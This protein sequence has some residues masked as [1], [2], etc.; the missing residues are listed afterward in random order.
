MIDFF[1]KVDFDQKVWVF[2]DILTIQHEVL[3][4]VCRNHGDNDRKY[5]AEGCVLFKY[6][7]NH[8]YPR[9]VVATFETEA[10]AEHAY[11]LILLEYVT[12][13]DDMPVIHWDAGSAAEFCGEIIRDWDS[14]YVEDLRYWLRTLDEVCKAG[15]LDPQAYVDMSDLGGEPLPKDIDAS[16]PVW[17]MDVDG[18]MLVGGDA[19]SIEHVDEHRANKEAA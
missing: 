16:Y 15:G 7:A 3:R 2:H 11:W 19:D 10:E 12:T 1:G 13:A 6:R 18:N 4:D 17:A 9:S 8:Q 14:E 5:R